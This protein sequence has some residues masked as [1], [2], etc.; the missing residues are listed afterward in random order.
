MRK[1]F[2]FSAM[3]AFGLAGGA[4]QAAT[5]PDDT[6]IVIDASYANASGH[7]TSGNIY[8]INGLVSVPLSMLGNAAL[9]GDFGYHDVISGGSNNNWLAGGTLFWALD[10][11]RFG[12]SSSY[13]SIDL[14]GGTTESLWNYHGAAEWYP[15]DMFT[16]G[17]K[18]GGASG[19]L[20]LSGWF[21]EG[22]VSAYLTPDFVVSG[23]VDY[24]KDDNWTFFSHETDMTLQGEYLVSH[25]TPVSVYAGYTWSEA[26][27]GFFS[28]TP[29]A[30]IVF[31][32]LKLYT[33]DGATT[34]VDHQR[35]GS[36]GWISSFAPLSV[37]F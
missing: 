8:G 35:N 31:V 1:L 5:I 13:H 3:V 36:A 21:T 30:S 24:A 26:H 11:T 2:F 32:G 7:N 18:V 27:V 34:L 14:G 10:S 17:A 19:G 37:K 15:S 29:H 12:V 20:G 16:V 22:I 4:A 9:Q 25:D 28:G 6:V 33:G 23:S